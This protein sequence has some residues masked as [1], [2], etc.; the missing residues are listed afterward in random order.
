MSIELS[1]TPKTVE[2]I[3]FVTDSDWDEKG[4]DSRLAVG[5]KSSSSSDWDRT[6]NTSSG[7]DEFKHINANRISVQT[8]RHFQQTF[9]P[10]SKSG[11]GDIFFVKDHYS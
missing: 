7:S 4:Q 3:F 5:I 6:V 11:P 2:R 8:E 1:S 9:S 10:D